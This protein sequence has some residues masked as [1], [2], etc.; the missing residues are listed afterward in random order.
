MKRAGR[1]GLGSEAVAVYVLLLV[2]EFL[3]LGYPS[4][5]VRALVYRL[6]RGRAGLLVQRFVRVQLGGAMYRAGGSF[7]AAAS[8][9]HKEQGRKQSRRQQQRS[10]SR[11]VSRRR[12]SRGKASKRERSP[13]Y[14]AYLLAKEKEKKEEAMREQTAAFRE[15]LDSKFSSFSSTLAAAGQPPG[16]GQ[17]PSSSGWPVAQLPAAGQGQPAQQPVFP[18]QPP[19]Q[20]QASPGPSAAEIALQVA[21][22]I[23]AGS[24]E[25]A[26]EEPRVPQEVASETTAGSALSAVKLALLEQVLNKS[27]KIKPESDAALTDMIVAECRS[28]RTAAAVTSFLERRG[29]PGTKAPRALRARAELLLSV[30]RGL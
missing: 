22:L 23:R 5:I 27:D 9:S 19:L 2:L 21:T 11:S 26:S 7:G 4:D 6:P 13:G 20:Q 14:E 29:A 17:P 8:G 25:A 16:Q 24:A 18:P 3:L 12:S 30:I 10:E 15:V 28:P 1:I